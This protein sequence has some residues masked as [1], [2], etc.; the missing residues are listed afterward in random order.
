MIIILEGADL[1]GK[2]TLARHLSTTLTFPIVRPWI[3]LA[4]PKP[5]IISV[6]KTLHQLFEHIQPD[7]IY[8]R[9]FFS[10]YV[11]A[12]VLGRENEYIPDLIQEWENIPGIFFVYLTASNKAIQTRYQERGGDWYVSLTQILAIRDAYPDLL[13]IVPATIPACELDT[14][15]LSPESLAEKVTSWLKEKHTPDLRKGQVEMH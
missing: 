13:K 12:A 4:H 5:S 9:F 11:Y 3:H 14:S 2:T 8:D 15:N 10:E 1:T 7:V 6:A